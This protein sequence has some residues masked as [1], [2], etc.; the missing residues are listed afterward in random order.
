MQQAIARLHGMVEV[1]RQLRTPPLCLAFGGPITTPEDL[2][3][4]FRHSTVQGFA[5]G[6]VFE[7]LPVKASVVSTI[8]R[9]KSTFL[10]GDHEAREAGGLGPII[11]R[12]LAMEALFELIRRVATANVNVC[13]EGET[14]TGK[15]LIATQIH[16]MSRRTGQ[17][18]IT[19]NCGHPGDAARKRGLFGHEK[20]AFTGP[21]AAD[22]ANSNWL[23]A[24]RCF[25]MKSPISAQGARV[26]LLRAIQQ[27]EIVRVGGEVS[28][29]VDVRIITA[30]NRPLCA[31]S[32]A[33][34][35][36]RIF[37]ID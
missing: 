11:G 28:I 5:G 3:Q 14:G 25:W 36:A 24:A 12:S 2:E 31:P 33:S 10:S 4:L 6:S 8:R 16:R 20:G 9:F 29:P 35:F 7:R 30:S 26:A 37:T 1:A 27:R 32:A 19:L 23:R 15:E 18:F 13:I 17:P 21:T 22:W 34:G